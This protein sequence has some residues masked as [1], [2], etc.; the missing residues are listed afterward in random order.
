M[1]K[2]VFLLSLPFVVL[3]ACNKTDDLNTEV[4]DVEFSAI[5]V[6]SDVTKTTLTETGS[7]T[8]MDPYTWTMTWTGDESFKVK[9][10]P[11]TYPH[12]DDGNTY[13]TDVG[14]A[15]TF[16]NSLVGVS[17]KFAPSPAG[18]FDPGVFAAGDQYIVSNSAPEVFVYRSN[19]E[20]S[21]ILQICLRWFFPHN[22][23]FNES[24]TLGLSDGII[25]VYGFINKGRGT[26]FEPEAVKMYTTAAVVKLVL[27][28]NSGADKTIDR[29]TM[30]MSG[31]DTMT[32][33]A[34]GQWITITPGSFP[35]IA[36]KLIHV[37]MEQKTLTLDCGDYELAKNETRV[38]S[39]VV[40][41]DL[42]RSKQKNLTWT[43]YEDGV[44][45]PIW[46]KTSEYD[47]EVPAKSKQLQSG[48]VYTVT[49]TL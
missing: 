27:T 31:T 41:G 16:T 7:G 44:V 35:A 10:F 46:S 30:S 14:S 5:A 43:V 36:S 1:K 21:D 26:G 39:F 8:V 34:G 49:G 17:S 48:K 29:I 38:F 13:T 19:T 45:D 18:S 12:P 20:T 15:Y 23:V 40:C 6:N 42:A 9:S 37:G 47:A 28:N 3:C 22:Q 24:N 25:P 11:T 33:L 4:S 32:G 2:F